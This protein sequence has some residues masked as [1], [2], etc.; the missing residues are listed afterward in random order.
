METI[1][2]MNKAGINSSAPSAASSPSKSKRKNQTQ[3]QQD[4]SSNR[5]LGVRRRP[6]GRYA[7]EIRDPTTKERH[8]LGTFDTAEE[9]ALAY[10]RAARSMRGSRA[11]TNFVYSDMPPGSSVTC[12][13]SPDEESHHPIPN[14]VPNDIY[15]LINPDQLSSSN[16][17]LLLFSDSISLQHHDITSPH[18]HQYHNQQL[19][20]FGG[21]HGQETSAP[22]PPLNNITASRTSSNYHF[23]P[24]DSGNNIDMSSSLFQQNT[25]NAMMMSSSCSHLYGGGGIKKKEANAELPPLPPDITSSCFGTLSE[26]PLL[27]DTGRGI[28]ND[29]SFLELS[30]SHRPCFS[31]SPSIDHYDD[32]II[33]GTSNYLGFD[34][35]SQGSCSDFV[36]RSF[37]SLD[38]DFGAHDDSTS[39]NN[40]SSFGWF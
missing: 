19:L 22:S 32:S 20:F 12:I 2:S 3:Q 6:W 29:M 11:R 15:N 16:G 21:H 14:I 7:A 10:D 35:S 4:S 31:G 30:E 27:S 23:S 39:A 9:A 18:R 33:A 5:F 24:G 34:A 8:W 13:V 38:Y 26:P 17:Q 37:S 1:R 25:T 28:L 36:H 40:F